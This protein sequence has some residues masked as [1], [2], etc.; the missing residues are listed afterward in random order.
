MSEAKPK[1]SEMSYS[2]AIEELDRLVTE[3]D[4]GSVDIDSLELRF[5]R[6]IEL[7]EDLDSRITRTREQVEKLMPRLDSAVSKSDNE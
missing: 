4:R 6:A 2:E 1:P 7:V 3:L 5:K